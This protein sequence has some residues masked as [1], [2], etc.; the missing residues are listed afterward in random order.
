M[1]VLLIDDDEDTT[2]LMDVLFKKSKLVE[3]YVIENNGNKAL[4][5][6]LTNPDYPDCI[7]V[8]L[9]MPDMNGFEFVQKYELFFNKQNSKTQVF[10]LSSSALQSDYEKAK[11]FQSVKE[12][13]TKP[14]NKNKLSN[15]RDSIKA[16]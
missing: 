11:S 3:S 10:F 13:I 1:N 15:I 14:L 12:F 8:D 4:E 9:K 5:H 2:F 7:F 6:L 16:C